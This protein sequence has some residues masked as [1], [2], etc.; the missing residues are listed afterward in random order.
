MALRLRTQV[1]EYPEWAKTWRSYKIK[2]MFLE[3]VRSGKGSFEMILDDEENAAQMLR[4]F[5]EALQWQDQVKLW[6]DL[7]EDYVLTI[8]CETPITNPSSLDNAILNMQECVKSTYTK[9]ERLRLM[10]EGTNVSFS[11]QKDHDL[12]EEI[13]RKCPRAEFEE[14]D[15]DRIIAHGADLLMLSGK[16]MKI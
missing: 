5:H 13:E 11:K 14:R 9:K 4:S 3:G 10:F 2:L 12:A 16:K 6:I 8:N 15:D 1:L 7:D